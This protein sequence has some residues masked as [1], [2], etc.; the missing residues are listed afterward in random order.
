MYLFPNLPHFKVL[1]D[2][3]SIL[4]SSEADFVLVSC[5]LCSSEWYQ[6]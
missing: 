4:I 5:S 1:I 3:K 2:V 6:K